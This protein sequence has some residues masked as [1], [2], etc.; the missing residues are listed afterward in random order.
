MTVVFA[1]T[2]LVAL[3]GALGAWIEVLRPEDSSAA[4]DRALAVILAVAGST[5]FVVSV[6]FA[7]CPEEAVALIRPRS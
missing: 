5:V 7:V 2:A 1:L 3:V 6:W 4:H